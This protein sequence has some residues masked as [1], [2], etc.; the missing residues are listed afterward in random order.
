MA[1]KEHSK[2]N[3]TDN[4]VPSE[5]SHM[6]SNTFEWY[7]LQSYSSDDLDGFDIRFI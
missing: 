5:I 6:V 7:E 1:I 2:S 3:S 4:R